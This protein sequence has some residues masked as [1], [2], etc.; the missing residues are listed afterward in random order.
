MVHIT[1]QMVHL[2][3]ATQKSI[4]IWYFNTIL[5]QKYHY[6]E[7]HNTQQNEQ[8]EAEFECSFNR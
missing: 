3:H 2:K 8:I 6:Y 5:F 7:K 4:I 1:H